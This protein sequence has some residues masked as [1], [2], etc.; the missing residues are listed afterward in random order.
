MT[1]CQRCARAISAVLIAG[2]TCSSAGRARGD[3]VTA[4]AAQALFEQGRRLL[5]EGDYPAA[6]AKLEESER[7]EPAAGTLLNLAYCHEQL[8]KTATAY[9]EY[10]DVLALSLKAHDEPRAILARQR[11]A[12]LEPLLARVV[13]RLPEVEVVGVEIELDG[14]RLGRDAFGVPI[15]VDPGVHRVSGRALGVEPF[16]IEVVIDRAGATTDVM[17]PLRAPAAA[18]GRSGTAAAKAAADAGSAPR[19][20]QD[21]SVT[22]DVRS[23]SPQPGS[24]IPDST[25]D[26]GHRSTRPILGGTALALSALTLAAGAYFG[27]DAFD[28]W[29][30]RNQH[31]PEGVCDTTAETAYRRAK[32]SAT[33]A[34][35][36]FA[37]SAVSGAAGVVLFVLPNA[38]PARGADGDRG[39]GYQDG[40]TLLIS[41][42][43]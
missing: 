23:P 22:S 39:A 11:T 21:R 9:V 14:T 25:R 27:I 15:P 13:I 17:V 30:R 38:P 40:V 4:P 43:F 20:A 36:C 34:D 32:R 1:F 19:T 2:A 37:T 7:L 26:A 29:A 6:C 10:Q 42:R 24:A 18:P 41:G 16:A 28:A 5:L 8:G 33:W 12:V 3:E 31:C 35:V